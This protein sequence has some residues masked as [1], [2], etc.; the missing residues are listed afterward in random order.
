M[1]E[2]TNHRVTRGETAWVLNLRGADLSGLGITER[3]RLGIGLLEQ[4]PPVIS[5]VKLRLCF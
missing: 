1:K 3:A 2:N 4:R 5:G